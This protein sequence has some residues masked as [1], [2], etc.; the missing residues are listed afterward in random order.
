M[1]PTRGIALKLLATFLFALMSA[2]IRYMADRYPVGQLVFVRSFFA[3]LPVVVVI[4]WRGEIAGALT[5]RNPLSHLARGL[6][7][8][9]GIFTTFLA[10]R[11]LP[12][13]DATA[14][15]FA[16]P[17]MAVVLAV[18]FLGEVVRAWRWSAVGVGLIGVVVMLWPHL[19]R[20][21]LSSETAIGA[22][23]GIAGAFF[24]ASAMTLVRHMTRSESTW[25][26]VFWFSALSALAG[27]L[28]APFGWPV[29]TP[30]DAALFVLMGLIGGVAQLLL[31]SSYRHASAAMLAPF[32]Y[33]A[34]IFALV[35][36][37]VAFR[38]VPAGLVLLGA[39]IVIAAGLFV[40]W[41]EHWLG[42]ERAAQRQAQGPTP[43]T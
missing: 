8:T 22:L 27:L 30:F 43:G 9:A 42:L 6:V 33:F 34:L 10:L 20:A 1:N 14:I 41:R 31:T 18:I 23:W 16:T 21:G 35:I 32:D 24:S 40:I 26:I 37:Y 7:G 25:S 29:P 3:M 13:A 12:L 38:E 36:G 4:A 39:A 28:T 5:M 11:Y 17:L 19:G 2:L 15:G